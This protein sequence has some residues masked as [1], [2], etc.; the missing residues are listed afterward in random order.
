MVA[1][2]RINFE[3]ATT[4]LNASFPQLRALVIHLVLGDP[5]P[6]YVGEQWRD[7]LFVTHI[8]RIYLDKGFIWLGTG[9]Y[10][11]FLFRRQ[12]VLDLLAE[13]GPMRI[14]DVMGEL[15]IP[16]PGELSLL[17]FPQ[18]TSKRGTRPIEPSMCSDDARPQRLALLS[19]FPCVCGGQGSLAR[20]F[21]EI[22]ADLLCMC[23]RMP[24]AG[25]FDVDPHLRF[26]EEYLTRPSPEEC[27]EELRARAAAYR[28]PPGG[29]AALTLQALAAEPH[30]TATFTRLREAL[31]G[32]RRP[33]QTLELTGHGLI[34]RLGDYRGAPW[35]LTKQGKRVAGELAQRERDQP[36][37]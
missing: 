9:H 31:G 4:A 1:T 23:R 20:R 27:R 35:A 8:Q 30:G 13:R 26:P 29:I 28:P 21:A 10:Q 33:L 5:L 6:E 25:E 11:V 12:A 19:L 16:R 2:G 3:A 37:S 34:E 14:A 7:P 22:P 17:T 36:R 18:R 24:R 32:G 15:L